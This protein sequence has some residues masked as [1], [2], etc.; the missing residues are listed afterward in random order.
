[1]RHVA[2]LFVGVVVFGAMADLFSGLPLRRF[3]RSWTAWLLGVAGLGV[4]YALAEL[5]GGWITD[6][7]KVTHPLWKRASV[8]RVAM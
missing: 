1:M 2:L 7:D 3:G 8:I 5:G 4:V 6:R